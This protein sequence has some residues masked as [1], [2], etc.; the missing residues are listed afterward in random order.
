MAS[1]K[2]HCGDVLLFLVLTWG[3]MDLFKNYKNYQQCE[4]PI[5]RWLI[6]S[7]SSIFAMRLYQLISFSLSYLEYK[8][9]LP[10]QDIMANRHHSIYV[11]IVT[12][13]WR[14]LPILKKLTYLQFLLFLWIIF[15]TIEGTVYLIQSLKDNPIGTPEPQDQTRVLASDAD[16]TMVGLQRVNKCLN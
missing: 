1:I 9:E 12:I 16:P 8:E 11:T 10:R 5:G 15:Q 7:M 13:D 6:I 4:M 2:L 14:V 3:T